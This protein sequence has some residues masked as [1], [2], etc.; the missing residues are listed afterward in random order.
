MYIVSCVGSDESEKDK[1]ESEKGN[2]KREEI[3]DII[4]YL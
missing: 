1:E 4:I 3:E 2:E